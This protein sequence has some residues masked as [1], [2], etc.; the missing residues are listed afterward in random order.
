MLVVVAICLGTS[1]CGEPPT[2][3][4]FVDHMVASSPAA[5]EAPGSEEQWT[6]TWGCVY[7][8]LDDDS[9]DRLMGLDEG[10]VPPADLSASVSKVIL[11]CSPVTTLPVPEGPL[12]GNIPG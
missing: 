7:G 6:E 5:S 4:E 3:A 1:A 12:P 8:K 10:E 11:E 2:R 9:V